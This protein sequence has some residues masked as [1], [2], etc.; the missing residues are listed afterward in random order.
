MNEQRRLISIRRKRDEQTCDFI[1]LLDAC[2][3]DPPAENV[4]SLPEFIR[5]TN[6][7]YIFVRS[8]ANESQRHLEVLSGQ[9]IDESMEI[10]CNSRRCDIH[11]LGS[12]FKIEARF[13]TRD[14]GVPFLFVDNSLPYEIVTEE[15][16]ERCISLR[17]QGA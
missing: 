11:P 15:V 12:I 1:G 9:G 3:D 8:C 10:E 14:G 6:F 2:M 5:D 16:A 13:A 17:T 7:K 4:M